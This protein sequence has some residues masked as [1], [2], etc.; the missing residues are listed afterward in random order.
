MVAISDQRDSFADIQCN[1]CGHVFTIMYNRADMTDWLSGSKLIQ[2]AFPYMTAGERELL[3]SG[4]C[5]TCFDSM[6][7]SEEELDS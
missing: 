6:F 7:S 4:I 5:S 3:L 2:D 1:M